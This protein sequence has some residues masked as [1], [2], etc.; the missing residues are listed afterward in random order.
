MRSSNGGPGLA[1]SPCEQG[2]R[3]GLA[4]CLPWK[5]FGRTSDVDASI[6]PVMQNKQGGYREIEF[7]SGELPSV[8]SYTAYIVHYLDNYLPNSS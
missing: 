1:R 5:H 7:G 2:K 4:A 6:L 8:F 3:R